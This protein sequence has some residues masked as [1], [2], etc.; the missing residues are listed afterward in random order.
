MHS[1]SINDQIIH[2]MMTAKPQ[3]FPGMVASSHN[4]YISIV[5]QEMALFEQKTNPENAEQLLAGYMSFKDSCKTTPE[6]HF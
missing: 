6:L 2:E 3:L 5:R 1:N 4:Y